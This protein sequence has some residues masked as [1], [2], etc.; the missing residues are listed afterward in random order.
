MALLN[1]AAL[2]A[3]QVSPTQ[4]MYSSKISP[5]NG[6][7]SRFASTWQYQ[8]LPAAATAPGAAAIPTR[9][10]AGALGQLNRPGVEQRAWLRRSYVGTGNLTVIYGAIML[11]DRLAHMSGLDGTSIVAQ[12]VNTPALT[13]YTNGVGVMA[14]YSIYTA[15]GA[16][17]QTI[18]STYDSDSGT[19][20]TSQA[21]DIGGTLLNTTLFVPFSVQAG[22]LGFKAVT[23]VTLSGSTG[24]VGNFGVTLY[25]PLWIWPYFGA[26]GFQFN[27]DPL[28]GFGGGG[29]PII[30][31]D[32]CLEYLILGGNALTLRPNCELAFFED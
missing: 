11:V 18:T 8:G 4:V 17:P 13:R 30:P 14:G 3:A 6:P 12:T 26:L 31:D 25:K 16:T 32:A 23:N 28:K 21:V 1:L 24:S 2:R 10:T 29:M 7:Q 9:A 5:A 22:D 19:G 27:G 20:H 15:I